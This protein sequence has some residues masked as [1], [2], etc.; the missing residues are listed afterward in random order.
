MESVAALV[1]NPVQ[2]LVSVRRSEQEVARGRLARGLTWCEDLSI[3]VCFLLLLLSFS[4]S[5][6]HFSYVT[7]LCP[8][9]WPGSPGASAYCSALAR[10]WRTVT[11]TCW[12]WWVRL[13]VVLSFSF[14]SLVLVP[15]PASCWLTGTKLVPPFQESMGKSSDGKSYII[16]GSWNPNTPQFQAVN[17]ETPKG[18]DKNSR[19]I[20]RNLPWTLKIRMSS[21]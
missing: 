15:L 11:C 17:E 8:L 14:L 20:S 9:Y 7:P 3:C 10:M 2:A 18:E 21:A 13:R 4:S 16:T 5:S 12:T 1:F 6:S 19:I